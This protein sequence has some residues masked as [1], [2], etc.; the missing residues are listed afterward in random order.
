MAGIFFPQ[1][2]PL[3]LMTWKPQTVVYFT[4]TY[5]SAQGIHGVAS[6]QEKEEEPHFSSKR[7]E[8]VRQ[9]RWIKGKAGGKVG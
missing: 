4:S 8:K 2:P 5:K 7:Y 3:H 1:S 6:G 9:G